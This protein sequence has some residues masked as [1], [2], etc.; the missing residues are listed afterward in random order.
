M[1]CLFHGDYGSEDPTFNLSSA[2][3]WVVDTSLLKNARNVGEAEAI[4]RHLLRG[5]AISWCDPGYAWVAQDVV[6]WF[7]AAVFLFVIL[8]Y[9]VI[10]VRA[11]IKR[12]PS[13]RVSGEDKQ[14]GHPLP[15]R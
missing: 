7:Y 8:P 1:V 3:S 4:Q 13:P 2:S 9:L 14:D 10:R 15:R 11:W 12:P 6:S 5:E